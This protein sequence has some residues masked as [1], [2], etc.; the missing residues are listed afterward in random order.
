MAYNARRMYEKFSADHNLDE[1]VS[2]IKHFFAK[3]FSFTNAADGDG[4][5]IETTKI[6]TNPHPFPVEL[7]TAVYSGNAGLTSDASN[8]AVITVKV[9]DG[10]NGTP[11]AAMT[12]NTTVVG[13]GT[14]TTD[15]AED[16]PITSTAAVIVPVG[17][18]VWYD[19]AIAGTGVVVP[20]GVLTVAYCPAGTVA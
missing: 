18:N 11:G 10:A 6:W 17:G 2:T 4:T 20:A 12:L 7:L 9:D 19:K 15:I 14:W 1:T 16:I 13:S 8:Y 3:T 5:S